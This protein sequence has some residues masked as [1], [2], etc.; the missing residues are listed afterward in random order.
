MSAGL[1][2]GSDQ[3]AS[4][5]D[6]WMTTVNVYRAMSG[7]GPVSENPTWSA[8]GRAHS[9]YMLQN[10]IAHDEIPGNPGY[11]SG[12]DVAGNSGNVAVSS[13][14]ST[15]ARQHVELWMTGP[16][17]AIGVLRHSLRSS[18]FGLCAQE[19]TPTPW[20]S[21]GTLDVIRGID[22]SAPRPAS[23]ILF[24]GNGATVPLHSFVTEFPNPLTMCGWSGAAG[25]PLIAMMPSDVSSASSTITG[26]TGPIQT[27]TLHRGNAS[28]AT[29]RAIL[30]GDNAV[31]VMPR[32]PLADGTYTVTV[33]TNGGKVTWSF[34]VDR[35]APLT[36][37]SQQ[38][39]PT[40]TT[41]P[42]TTPTPA[43]TT[44]PVGT[45]G[46]TTAS[47]KQ[48]RFRPVAPFRLVDSRTGRGT[49][50][51]RA[52]S[53][54]RVDVADQSIAAVSAN[55]VAVD[56]QNHGFVTAY[57]CTSQRPDVSTLSFRPGQVVA[58]QA[59][60]PLAKGQLCL[61]SLVDTDIVIDVNGYFDD[62]GSSGFSPSSP[63]R[64]HDTRADGNARLQGGQELVLSVA[65]AGRPAP[66]GATS[67][68]LNVTVA[69]TADNGFL[70]V[71]PCGSPTAAEISTINYGPNEFRPNSVVIPVDVSGNICIRSLRDTHAIIDYTG[72]FADDF[73]ADFLPLSPIRLFDSRSGNATLNSATN[74]NR[75]AGGQIVGIKVAGQRGIPAGATAV[76]VN[77]TAT[78][79]TEGSFLT[80]FQC[81]ERPNTSN[82]NIVPWQAVSANG[83]MVKLSKSGE[84]CVFA[85]NPVHVIVDISGVYL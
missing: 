49:V 75:V 41:T 20:R 11:T 57:N 25:L 26:P 53:V 46:D 61:F 40:P 22:G 71:Y 64:I 9:C 66:A 17:H 83:A 12:G 8:E 16:F 4:A 80:V 35:N 5:A 28:D 19:S 67:V 70:Q 32:D 31:V 56:P 24:P 33:N 37:S 58:N 79:A 62:T 78:D 30:A 54:T 34:N 1:V 50:R 29:A 55:F 47:S 48:T 18:G 42:T 3:P 27:C 14:I 82:V 60:V 81:G 63:Q 39:T 13:N 38:P 77:V 51:L 65:G 84:L 43:P 76:T 44:E 69:E 85:L 15:T 52:G 68:A 21:G 36:A 59:V 2:A 7:L 72:F 6:D 10:G 73:G 74:G 23:P 45:P